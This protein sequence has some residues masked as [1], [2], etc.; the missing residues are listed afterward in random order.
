MSH[1]RGKE[2]YIVPGVVGHDE[3]K[4]A[5]KL[6]LPIL[7]ADPAIAQAYSS[8]SGNKRLFAA[9]EVSTPPAAYD[10]YE[11]NEIYLHL[12]RLVVDYPEYQRWVIKIDNEYGGRGIA[13]LDTNKIRC[14]N[15][16]ER[17]KLLFDLQKVDQANTFKNVLRE[18]VYFDIKESAAKKIKIVRTE[19]YP[20]WK[21]Y[22]VNFC[23][24]GGVIE[25]CPNNIVGSPNVNIFIEPDGTVTVL[26]S[27]EQVF[28]APFCCIGAS[29]PQTSVPFAALREAALTIGR[30]CYAKKIMGHVTVDFVAFTKDDQIRIW[31]VDL[32]LN[33]TDNSLFHQLFDFVL[34]GRLNTKTG[35]YSMRAS[36]VN[37]SG[38]S[39]G[40]PM[41]ELQRSESPSS[42]PKSLL[43]RAYVY[44]GLIR[45]PDLKFVRH[46][47][48]FQLCRQKGIS[49]DIQNKVG[50]V[51]HMVDSL[52]RGMIGVLCIGHT[53]P[54]AVRTLS[55]VMDFI[56]QEISK[57]AISSSGGSSPSDASGTPT[58]SST[59]L[60][61][62]A[63]DSDTNLDLVMNAT[64]ILV[65][66]T[67][68][69]SASPT[70]SLDSTFTSH[71]GGGGSRGGGGIAFATAVA[72][73]RR[74]LAD[75]SLNSSTS[76]IKMTALYN[77][78]RDHQPPLSEKE[79]RLQEITNR[80]LRGVQQQQQQQEKPNNGTTA[81]ATSSNSGSTRPYSASSSST[82][83][84]GFSAYSS[85]AYSRR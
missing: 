30:I 10:L 11:E 34:G 66:Q 25:A 74:G 69:T 75:S 67:L 15:E 80:H 82:S 8:K 81:T 45:H 52:L 64:R 1:I 12:S 17:E 61:L 77:N 7:G 29:F 47:P 6:Q 5:L 46:G 76:S 36:S 27:Q 44:S 9:A 65:Q 3:L 54:E 70:S 22:L 39:V 71:S 41:P 59:A 63:S 55:E 79:S 4:L 31:A 57:Q 38:G 48:F 85:F 53:L 18:R 28:G 56:V 21:D 58:L 14:L 78:R 42:L 16:R 2:A 24:S 43:K 37:S 73:R 26:S 68:S 50:T 51:F 83:S 60:A 19:I 23:K 62:E 32:K 33:L 13:Y 20:T 72:G 84:S 40:S 35:E 49:F